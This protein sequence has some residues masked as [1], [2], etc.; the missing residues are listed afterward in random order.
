VL[1]HVAARSV[2]VVE[3]RAAPGAIDG[4]TPIAQLPGE[5]GLARLFH[6]GEATPIS[7]NIAAW[8]LSGVPRDAGPSFGISVRPPPELAM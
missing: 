6:H 8:I 4:V 7:I 3:L 5:K 2:V 1:D